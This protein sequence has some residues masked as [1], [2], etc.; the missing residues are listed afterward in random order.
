MKGAD[1]GQYVNRVS[2]FRIYCSGLRRYEVRH[3]KRHNR[4]RRLRVST[5]ANTKRHGHRKD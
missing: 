3:S 5:N 1:R 2:E 4:L